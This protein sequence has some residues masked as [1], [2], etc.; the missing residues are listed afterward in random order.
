M[1][2]KVPLSFDNKIE[3]YDTPFLWHFVKVLEK[4][5][6][7]AEKF[8]ENITSFYGK[9]GLNEL[10]FYLIEEVSNPFLIGIFKKLNQFFDVK[11]P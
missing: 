9:E 10:V 1:F 6:E 4:I 11:D 7:Q 5:N 8:A 3:D 2:Q